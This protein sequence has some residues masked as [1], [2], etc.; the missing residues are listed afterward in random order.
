MS[1]IF[2]LLILITLIYIPFA[3]WAVIT[4][5]KK[6][7]V[8]L[9][10]QQDKGEKQ[11][12]K[13]SKEKSSS[14]IHKAIK[15]A[16]KILVAAELKGMKLIAT[17]KMA[18]NKL[19]GQYQEHLRSLEENLGKQFEKIAKEGEVSYENFAKRIEQTI[20]ETLDRNEKMLEQKTNIFFD[21]AQNE[22]GRFTTDIHN[23]IRAQ[24]D[25][26][27]SAARAEIAEYKKHRLKA[28]DENIIE[29][30]EKTLEVALGKKLSLADQS[31]LI[32]K[33]LEEAKKEHAF[34][35]E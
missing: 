35:G 30:L 3:V 17:E 25:Q 31:E 4:L 26:E 21:N 8:S 33:A 29:I 14:I 6:D 22:L 27:L 13:E 2:F 20:R 34:G 11:I 28:L 32:Y 12:L 9:E 16:N 19:A 15:Q 5:T 1:N 10:D 7:E 18:S 23:K 24:I